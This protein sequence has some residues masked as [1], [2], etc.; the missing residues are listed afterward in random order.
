MLRA[1]PQRSAHSE[2][3]SLAFAVFIVG[4][5]LV[6]LSLVVH[7]FPRTA[8]LVEAVLHHAIFIIGFWLIPV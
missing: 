8:A 5:I 7:L 2:N 1:A 6:W 4:I 3:I